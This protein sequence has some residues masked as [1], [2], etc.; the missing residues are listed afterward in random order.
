MKKL[1]LVGLFLCASQWA[2]AQNIIYFPKEK[3]SKESQNW[4]VGHLKE[5]KEHSLWQ[6]RLNKEAYTYRHLLLSML[7]D[8]LS[9]TVNIRQDKTGVLIIKEMVRPFGNQVFH[10]KKEVEVSLTDKQVIEF[11]A[12]F[13]EDSFW[14]ENSIR[15]SVH[16]GGIQWVIEG[17]KGGRYNLVEQWAPGER[18][19][20]EAVEYLFKVADYQFK[21]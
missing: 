15:K 6:K 19:Y 18:D 11:L 8:P 2:M 20:P 13:E 16:F 10:Q 1:I 7:A 17:I 4:Y 12:M 3:L 5:L 9:V 14:K 21:K